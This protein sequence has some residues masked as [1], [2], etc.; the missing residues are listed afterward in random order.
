MRAQQVM[1]T[2]E[3]SVTMTSYPGHMT[4][5]ILRG[6]DNKGERGKYWENPWCK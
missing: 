3:L 2:Y 5:P 4:G 6:G 1:C